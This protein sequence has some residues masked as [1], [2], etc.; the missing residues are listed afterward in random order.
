MR[1]S[2]P[3]PSCIAY[4]GARAARRALAS[5]LLDRDGGDLPEY[6]LGPAG[7]AFRE[8]VRAWLAENWT[9][10]RK[11][12]FQSRPFHDREFDASFAAD[13]G[14]TGW[15]GLAWPR[16]FG[17]QERTPLEQIAFIEEM[18]RAEA[19]SRFGATVQSNA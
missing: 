15:L 12:E 13:L 19:P 11:A 17:G 7:T 10:E 1:S 16:A 4:G 14:K 9:A 5:R 8:E 2:P 6:D 18:E 3:R